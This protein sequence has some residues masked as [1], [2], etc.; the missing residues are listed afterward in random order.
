MSMLTAPDSG[1]PP[2]RP[3]VSTVSRSGGCKELEPAAAEAFEATVDTG[4][5][6]APPN[7]VVEESPATGRGRILF[8]DDAPV[9]GLAVSR[10]LQSNGY[11]VTLLSNSEEVRRMME[12]QPG[13]FDVLLV[14]LSLGNQGGL[15]LLQKVR[16]ED[17]SIVGIIVSSTSTMENALN[18]L[19]V[20]AFDFLS[21]PLDLDYAIA[22]LDRAMAHRRLLVENRRYQA[23]LEELVR[24]KS[25]AL[26][27]ALERVRSTFLFTLEALAATIDAR[28]KHTGDHSK[29]VSIMA[30]VVARAMNTP[31][32]QV[33][34]IRHGGLLHDIGKI[35]M[36]DS[37]LLKQGA[38]SP[39]EWVIVRT[40]PEVGYNILNANP[41][42][43]R[44]AEI[45]R[46]HQ[47]RYDGKGYPR[48]L[49]GKNICLGARIFSV[50]DAYDTI[51]V[52][53]P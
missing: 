35:A 4:P 17:D 20:G 8:V 36:P 50:A 39:E 49:A 15:D 31:E 10:L 53:R 34:I 47:E 11:Q 1:A 22:A 21:K 19:R 27:T 13:H 52:G 3:S 51:R 46:S 5:R 9:A 40:H 43:E 6:V 44:V 7:G 16:E 30:Q 37:I 2:C 38:L 23:G 28:E 42:W 24:D 32:D 45:V 29:R 41:D 25:A 33:E 14:D 12:L 26:V 48:G 18:A